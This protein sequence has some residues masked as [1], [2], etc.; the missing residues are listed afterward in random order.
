[1]K[2]WIQNLL[3][4][5]LTIISVNLLISCAPK[6]SSGNSATPA[7][8]T[9][10]GQQVGQVVPQSPSTTNGTSDS[11]GGTGLDGKVFESYIVDP[12]ELPAYKQ[13]LEPLLKNINSEQEKSSQYH[14]I[15]KIKTW[16]IAPVDLDKVSKDAL[17]V[18]FM[19]SDTQ[20]IARQSMKEI[21]ID[22]RIY[23]QMSSNDQSDLLLHELVMNL[24]FFKFLKISEICKIWITVNGETGNEGCVE[25]GTQLDKI[26]PPEEK[27]SL[28]DQDNENIRY[29]TGWLKQ[30][31]QQTIAEK[32]FV[33]VL[34]HKN[35]DKRFF[36]PENYGE[37]PGSMG[38]LKISK[39]ELYQAIKGTKL[40]GHMPG[41]CHAVSGATKSCKIELEEKS[42]PYQTVQIPGL[43]IS[44]RTENEPPL[45]LNVIAAD[46]ITLSASRD[47]EGRI[48]YTYGI[49]EWR[50]KVQMGDRIHSGFFIFK[51]DMGTS[52]PSLILDSIILRPGIVVSIDKKRNPVC[53]LRAPN[54]VNF[55]DDKISIR[56][57]NSTPE[58]IE[59]LYSVAPPFAA[60][61]ADNVV[62]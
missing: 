42:I 33:R 45:N 52:Q 8:P 55:L 11:G 29:V 49:V 47:N 48:F 1:M 17:G 27:R 14:Q 60:C 57:E 24:Y 23:D 26:M 59:Q 37:K 28:T 39:K 21:W 19:K 6:G 34:F 43:S 2:N 36:R 3:L 62:E 9:T 44:L 50:D 58:V 53:M 40:S 7:N 22:K 5:T 38:E 61:S 15:F 32:D 25:N 46:E 35:F 30:N 10:P 41:T 18:S 54:V 13:H 16:Y 56:K 12:T 51:K 20:Q 31:A 4:T